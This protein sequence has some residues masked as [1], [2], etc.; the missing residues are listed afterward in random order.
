MFIDP[1][2]MALIV[3]PV[4]ILIG[5]GI[6]IAKQYKRCPSNKIIVVYGKT[7]GDKTAKCI[8]GGGTF[9]IPLIQ[10]F[11]VLSLGPMT[12]DIDL[13]GALSKGNIR[14]AVPSTFTFGIS[15]KESIMINAAERLL[16]LSKEE[17]IVQASDIILGQL[18]L[19][20]ATL[21]ICLLY[22]SPSPRD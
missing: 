13:R 7:G 2:V 8:H 15:T 3:V 20:I 6:F 21:T 1:F 19:A 11:G 16:G 5:L 9:V 10:D 22:T 14:V 4:I 18:R 17:I 12:T